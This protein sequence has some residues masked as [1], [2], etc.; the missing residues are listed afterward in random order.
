MP[1]Q[2][3]HRSFEIIGTDGTVMLQ[4]IEGDC[5]MRVT[6]RQARG[7][8]KEGTQVA[9]FPRQSRYTGDFRE[10]AAAIREK[11][12]LKYSYDYELMLHE[13]ILRASG[14]LV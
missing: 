9:D 4:P 5:K 11:R 1:G 8:Y 2:T 12:P 13:A 14:E 10:L 3:P 6:L 7:P